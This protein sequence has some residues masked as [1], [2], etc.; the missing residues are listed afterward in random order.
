MFSAERRYKLFNEKNALQ[1][2]LARKCF[3]F[4]QRFGI[5]ITGDHF[6]EIIPNTN[7]VAENYSDEPRDLPF[8]TSRY[9]QVEQF[10]ISIVDQYC[11]EFKDEV[12][13]FG[14]VEQNPYYRAMDSVVLYCFVRHLKPNHV[15]E[16]GQGTST[17]ITMAALS[18]NYEETGNK[19]TF[20]SI[21]PYARIDLQD[22]VF[23]N[24]EI[25]LEQ[26]PVQQ[27]SANIIDTLHEGDFLF[28]D[29][30]HVYKFGSDVE[31]EFDQL[32]PGLNVGVYIHIHDVFTPYYPPLDWF[33]K[34]KWFW[35]EQYIMEQFLRFNDDFE[36]I[37]PLYYIERNSS[38]FRD[39]ATRVRLDATSLRDAAYYFRRVQRSE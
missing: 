3:T 27:A 24:V 16:V 25:E 20:V 11:G 30:S 38:A 4:F 8:V 7:F 17:R 36:T 14:Y 21:D 19:S 35:N 39:L 9:E 15:V 12:T 28:I 23:D 29:S 32:Y 34:R 10:A 5:H 1:R 33:T 18:K 26:K 37:L 13:K 22:R 6:Y 31:F 2:Y